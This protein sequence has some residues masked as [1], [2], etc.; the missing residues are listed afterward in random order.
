M[1]QSN[2]NLLVTI[3]I[4][5]ELVVPKESILKIVNQDLMGTKELI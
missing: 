3:N 4:E 5:K 2:N 1:D